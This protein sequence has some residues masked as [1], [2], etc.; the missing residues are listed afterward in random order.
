MP[1]RKLKWGL[2]KEGNGAGTT[3]RDTGHIYQE[4]RFGN[5]DLSNPWSTGILPHHTGD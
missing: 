3:L 1:D 2:V 4:G 5:P